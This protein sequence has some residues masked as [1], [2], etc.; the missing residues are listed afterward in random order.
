MRGL[1]GS[2]PLFLTHIVT[3]WP[4]SAGGQR[5]LVQESNLHAMILL[6]LV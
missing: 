6:P 2:F 4:F 3:I 5:P 1:S